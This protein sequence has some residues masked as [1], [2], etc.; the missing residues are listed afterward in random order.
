MIDKKKKINKYDK[1]DVKKLNA[2]ITFLFHSF[3]L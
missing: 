2:D 1:I 3:S